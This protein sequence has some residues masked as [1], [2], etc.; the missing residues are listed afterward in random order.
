MSGWTRQFNFSVEIDLD[1]SR[2]G[3]CCVTA[4]KMVYIGN[5]ILKIIE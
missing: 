3:L 5:G 2:V 4:G 1:D